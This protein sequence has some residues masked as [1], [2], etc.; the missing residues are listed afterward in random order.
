MSNIKENKNKNR[1]IQLL[2][3]SDTLRSKNIVKILAADD[4]CIQ[5]T[6]NHMY[7][8]IIIISDIDKKSWQKT[9]KNFRDAA[10][11][12]GI[13]P[14]H[15][16]MLDSTLAENYQIIDNITRE[17]EENASKGDGTEQDKDDKDVYP[18]YKYSNNRKGTLQEAIILSGLPRFIIYDKA[19]EEL[20]PVEKIEEPSRVLR[21]PNVEEYPYEPYEYVDSEELN[22]YL[23][24]AKEESIYSLYQKWKFIVKKYNDQDEYKQ[25]LITTDLLW[26]YFQDLF[27]TTHYTAAIGDNGSGKSS[28]GDTFEHGAYRCINLTNPSAPNVFR[29][30]GGIEPGQCT[31][32][33]DEV[34]RLDESSEMQSILKTGYRYGKRVPKINTNSWNQEFFFTYCFKLFL[35]ESSPSQWKSKGVLDRI[36]TFTTYFG[37]PN[38][39]IEEITD[40]QGDPERR[41]LL[42]E[43]NDLRK[44]MLIY[45]MVHFADPISDIDTTVRGRNMQLTKPYIQ[46]FFGT[47]AQKEVEE[48]LQKFLDIKNEKRS[49]SIEA[50]LLPIIRKLL[51]EETRKEDPKVPV[52]RI[53]ETI[54]VDVGEENSSIN[55]NE[56]YT[57]Y[58][59]LYRNTITK[60][61]C[62][63]FGA[64]VKRLHGGKRALEF[65]LDKLRK[66]EKAYG[67][68]SRILTTSKKEEKD[69]GGNTSQYTNGDGGD[70]YDSFRR[71]PAFTENENNT[72]SVENCEEIDE[73]VENISL[74]NEN[75]IKQSDGQLSE[76]SG[77]EDSIPQEPSELSPLSPTIKIEGKFWA[78]YQQ[79]LEKEQKSP[80]NHMTIDKDTISG[81]ALISC[82]YDSGEFSRTQANEFIA[83]AVQSG[84]LEEVSY[85]TYRRRT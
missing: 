27:P 67:S 68:Q 58:G 81:T 49:N 54:K 84:Q 46:L 41:K 61:I 75:I 73:N 42:D 3:I 30:L 10:A 55:P 59:T 25:I 5:V 14:K 11:N 78:I 52:S 23:K 7:K 18:V 38:R 48:T 40:P 53:W 28:I 60:I 56:C 77:K 17:Q 70:G 4:R 50:I 85:D 69:K 65:N 82:L 71:M 72:S 64:E 21:P 26:T 45:R 35:A 9:V 33:L 19:D 12:K 15:I 62:D 39:L 24:R 51:S 13:D 2:K 44:L 83:K 6:L 57:D 34:D 74:D 20:V 63:K 22:Y 31:L 79:L 16:G 36:L 29:I 8:D 1:K 32:I 66:I 76:T 37:T 47:P 43:L 80:S